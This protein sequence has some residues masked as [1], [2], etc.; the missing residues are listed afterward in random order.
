[1]NV[2]KFN[3]VGN[4]NYT[5]FAGKINSPALRYSAQK[6]PHATAAPKP[7]RNSSNLFFSL[8]GDRA[9]ISDGARDLLKMLPETM[10][11]TP[12][13]LTAYQFNSLPSP[14]LDWEELNITPAYIPSDPTPYGNL[15]VATGMP[16]IE[17][18]DDTA[19]ESQIPALPGTSHLD[20]LKPDGECRTCA[21][22]RYV[23]KSD[24]PSVSFQTP[25]HISPS[26]SAA[27]VASHEQEHVRSEQ[28][29]AHREDRQIISQSVSLTFDCCPECGRNYVSG[30]TTRT[31]SVSKSDSSQITSF[32]APEASLGNDIDAA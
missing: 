15:P 5:G 32:D 26:M 1:V 20:S 18:P 10:P 27:A 21:D 30:G 11:D 16:T 4:V 14:I 2:G 12:G 9:E 13:V 31:T 19:G 28:A 25:T 29:R 8:D 22:R 23:D 7:S 6:L 3:N 24:D 17:R